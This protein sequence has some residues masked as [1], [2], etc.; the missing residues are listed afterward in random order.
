MVQRKHRTNPVGLGQSIPDSIVQ[1]IAQAIATAEGSFSS[2]SAL[3][4]RANNPGDLMLGDIGFGTINGKTIYATVE[5][6]WNALYHQVRLMLT[7]V[8]AYYTPDMT[9]TQMAEKYTGGDNPL[10]WA[11]NVARSLGVS[12]ETKLSDLLGSAAAAGV[13]PQRQA[14]DHPPIP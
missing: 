6:G 5:D 10:S 12:I 14:G 2:P 7:G 3:P 11:M 8:S 13:L 9:I 1:S 4:R